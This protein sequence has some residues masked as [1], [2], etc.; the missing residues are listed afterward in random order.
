MF[1]LV[2]GLMYSFVQNSFF[3]HLEMNYCRLSVLYILH[4]IMTVADD[5]NRNK[6]ISVPVRHLSFFHQ[7]R[8]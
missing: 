1:L 2:V 6:H 8:P 7:V 3:T 4:M 5:T